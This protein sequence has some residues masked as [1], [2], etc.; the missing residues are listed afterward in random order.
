MKRICY[1]TTV[2]QTLEAFVLEAARYVHDHTDWDITF[3]CDEDDRFRARLPSY[4]HYVPVRMERGIR[5]SGIRSFRELR[6]ILAAQRFDL[7]QYS[8]PNASL[9]A[10]L[11]GWMTGIPV[12]LYCQWGM[13][14]V[15]ASGIRRAVFKAVE[16][17]VCRLSTWIEP[18]SGSNLRFAHEEGLYPEDVGSVIWN[19]SACG[20]SLEKFDISRKSAYRARIRERY[21]IPQDAF[22]FG[23][24]GRITHD[25]GI[26]ELLHAARTLMEEDPDLYLMLVGAEELDGRID[27]EAYRWS[28]DEARVLYC[29]VT[30]VVEQYLS[31]MD[32]FLLPSYREGFGMGVIEAEAMGV[33]VI[34]SD[35]PGPVDAMEEG[36]TGLTVRKGDADDLLRAM[37]TMLRDDGFRERAGAY[38][39]GYVRSRFERET[40]MAHMLADRERLLGG[41]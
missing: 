12:R 33:P 31:G 27:R 6:K 36:R 32:C 23:S 14:Y 22:V 38:A 40:F 39:S 17:T 15:G 4:I 21:G 41:P 13:A 37:R 20:I 3:I 2:P 9:Y 7:I 11:A 24:V 28:R 26:N 10:S 35:I 29:G 8:T 16:K 34:V 25:K 1:I 30:D 19:G 18:D 5:P